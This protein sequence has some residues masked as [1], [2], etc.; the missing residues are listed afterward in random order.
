M[1]WEWAAYLGVSAACALAALPLRRKPV[2][3]TG[4]DYRALLTTLESELPQTQCGRCG[5]VSCRDYAKAVAAGDHTGRCA[6]GG[7]PVARA[8]AAVIA[9]VALSHHPKHQ[10]PDSVR[11]VAKIREEPCIGCTKCIQACP[12]DAIIGAPNLM[13]NVLEDWCT[14]CDLCIDVCPVDCIDMV[15]TDRDLLNDT[16]RSQSLSRWQD[17]RSRHETFRQDRHQPAARRPAVKRVLHAAKD[18][19]AR[20]ALKRQSRSDN[21]IASSQSTPHDH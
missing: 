5:Y 20:R 11:R 6:P 2:T 7:A 17:R 12:V 9:D 8:L 3:P 1:M 13:H 10:L 15:E 19:I 21:I 18:A 4:E 14:G 16:H